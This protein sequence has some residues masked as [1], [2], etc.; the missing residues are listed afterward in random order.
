MD[1]LPITSI[2]QNILK[3]DQAEKLAKSP[4]AIRYKK[5]KQVR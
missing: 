3:A 2:H 5:K 1:A 4:D